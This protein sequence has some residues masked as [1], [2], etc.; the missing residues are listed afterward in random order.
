M[1]LLYMT[2]SD[3]TLDQLSYKFVSSGIARWA[4]RTPGTMVMKLRCFCLHLPSL[5]CA[6]GVEDTDDTDDAGEKY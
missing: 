1:I 4:Q 2:T 3:Y 5:A 6:C